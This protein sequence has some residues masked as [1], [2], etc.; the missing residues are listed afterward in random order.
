MGMDVAFSGTKQIRRALN[1][2]GILEKARVPLSTQE[3]KREYSEIEFIRED[4]NAIISDFIGLIRSWKDDYNKGI[5]KWEGGTQNSP[6]GPYYLNINKNNDKDTYT[7]LLRIAFSILLIKKG[8]MSFIDEFLEKEFPLS[9]LMT[10]LNSVS[11]KYN[12]DSIRLEYM[13][14]NEE[15]TSVVSIDKITQNGGEWMLI[16]KDSN[17][18]TLEI[19][20]NNIISATKI[21]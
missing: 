2:L 19:N 7:E 10:L 16:C 8:Q 20:F 12:P 21:N 18:R 1:F 3:L 17:S 11:D 13:N 6:R 4:N 14:G 9:I 15:V 5:V